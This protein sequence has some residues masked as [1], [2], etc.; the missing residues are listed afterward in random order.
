MCKIFGRTGSENSACLLA[1]ST[2][3]N[4]YRYSSLPEYCIFK[5]AVYKIKRGISKMKNRG[6]IKKEPYIFI[7]PTIIIFLLVLLIPMVNLVIFS[8]G[9]SNIIQGYTGYGFGC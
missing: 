7:T 1:Q 4:Y 3:T 2:N 6:T 5:L 8:L 9:D